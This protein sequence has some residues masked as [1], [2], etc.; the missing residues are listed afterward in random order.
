MPLDFITFWKILLDFWVFT[1][2]YIPYIENN[3]NLFVEVLWL[4]DV[5]KNE[6]Q[7]MVGQIN[8]N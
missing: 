7:F 8:E 4:S 6:I 1:Q 5:Q 2:F 3:L